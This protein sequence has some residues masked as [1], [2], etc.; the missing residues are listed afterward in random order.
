MPAGAD[1][2]ELGAA[3][4]HLL[5]QVRRRQR[6]GEQ[7]TLRRHQLS[8]GGRV[9]EAPA[10]QGVRLASG[11][12]EQRG[13][14][15]LGEEPLGVAR[16]HSHAWQVRGVL[17]ADEPRLPGRL[18][19]RVGTVERLQLP[20]PAREQQALPPQPRQRAGAD[21]G[22]PLERLAEHGE[23]EGDPTHPEADG[24]LGQ[25]RDHQ[26]HQPVAGGRV[27]PHQVEREA[28]AAPGDEAEE[29]TQV[30]FLVSR[31]HQDALPVERVLEPAERHREA[32]LVTA[33]STPVPGRVGQGSEAL[34]RE[35]PVAQD[36]A[37]VAV[38]LEPGH[39]LAHR[40]HARPAE[41]E[42]GEV[43][44]GL[45]ADVEG[46]QAGVRVGLGPF[47]AGTHHR[48]GQPGRP[49]VGPP[50]LDRLGPPERVAHGVAA[51]EADRAEDSVRH[52][53]AGLGRVV[54]VPHHG[55]VA[56]GGEVA[57]RV[58]LPVVPQHP[59]HPG[60]VRD[61]ERAVPTRRTEQQGCRRQHDRGADDPDQEAHPDRCRHRVAP[62]GDSSDVGEHLAVHEGDRVGVAVGV[63]EGVDQGGSTE[64]HDRTAHEEE[65]GGRPQVAGHAEGRELRPGTYGEH[66]HAQHE[67][68]PDHVEHRLG[69]VDEQQDASDLG[70]HQPPD[71]Q[72]PPRRPEPAPERDGHHGEE[73]GVHQ[74][75]HDRDGQC[76]DGVV[77]LGEVAVPRRH[78]GHH[79][80]E[81]RGGEHAQ[82]EAVGPPVVVRRVV[83]PVGHLVSLC[84]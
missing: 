84:P 37:G 71:H 56:P 51:R 28:V 38:P 36:L 14:G 10:L 81:R 9:L 39:G 48:E 7:V 12:A 47:L 67:D 16:G 2:V 30:P 21:P 6:L 62:A 64:Q 83:H 19:L 46:H 43:D 17:E 57:E 33:V 15:R 49:G 23:V 8:Y 31:L 50:P 34:R 42:L 82:G 1:P 60:L 27:A 55:L 72:D 52:P 66:Q 53:G 74:A 11:A 18:V 61:A 3:Y 24:L 68:E 65:R 73:A 40:L 76:R 4:A 25:G 78:Q 32:T 29:P 58:P 5:G 77:R 75:G 13:Q 20:A 22:P 35:G 69:A 70:H 79:E 54:G 59:A 45:V 80:D 41:G 26:L 44:D 63:A